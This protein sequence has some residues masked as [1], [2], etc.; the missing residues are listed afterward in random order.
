M[1]DG[2]CQSGR[3]RRARSATVA[4]QGRE[5]GQGPV[6]QG[7]KERR[8]ERWWLTSFEWGKRIRRIRILESLYMWGCNE[9]LTSLVV[10]MANNC[11]MLGPA[12][13][14]QATMAAKHSPAYHA[15]IASGPSRVS[16]GFFQCRVLCQKRYISLTR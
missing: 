1:H 12:L 4:S 11:A 14:R 15:N 16:V 9:L 2:I 7:V 3:G 13:R 10:P 6:M 5:C 8:I